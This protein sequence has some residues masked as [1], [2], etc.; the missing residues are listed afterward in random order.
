MIYKLRAN[1]MLRG[2][3]KYSWKLVER[4]DN[5]IWD[6]SQDEFQILL[7]CDGETDLSE[8]ILTESMK[9]F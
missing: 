9:K 4:P 3:R 6:L 8:N 7:L 5:F 2:W 1:Y